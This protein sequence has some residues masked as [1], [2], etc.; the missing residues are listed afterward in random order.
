[1]TEFKSKWERWGCA[2][3]RALAEQEGIS[4]SDSFEWFLARERGEAHSGVG[5][6]LK[7]LAARALRQPEPEEV[8]CS[9]NFPRILIEGDDGEFTHEIL[10]GG[11]VI[12]YTNNV[13]PFIP[14]PR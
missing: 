9:F 2:E 4:L 11:E 14:R 3:H 7:Q 6:S 8:K 12:E 1:M 13:V 10:E 5:V